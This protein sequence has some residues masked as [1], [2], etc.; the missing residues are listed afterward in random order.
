VDA[1]LHL[2][3]QRPRDRWPWRAPLPRPR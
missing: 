2:A 1:R 3:E